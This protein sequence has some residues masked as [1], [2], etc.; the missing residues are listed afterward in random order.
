MKNFIFTH[1]ILE[2]M[3]TVSRWNWKRTVQMVCRFM[4]PMMGH[5][6]LSW[7]EVGVDYKCT[8]MSNENLLECEC[9]W[10]W[11]SVS[12]C[13]HECVQLFVHCFK[14]KYLLR[15][16][17]WDCVRA[18]VRVCVHWKLSVISNSVSY[19]YCFFLFLIFDLLHFPIPFKIG[20]FFFHY[21]KDKVFT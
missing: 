1:V 18:C 13:E 4:W 20:A 9:E 8:H 16:T 10:E 15:L 17:K 11:V 7:S 14:Q 3:C 5:V 21:M 2:T 6:F 12:V 19:C